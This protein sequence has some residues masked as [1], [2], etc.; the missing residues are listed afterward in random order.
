MSTEPIHFFLPGPAYVLEEVRQ[1]LTRPIVSHRSSSFREV[2]GRIAE[3][4]PEIFR[5][6]GE[7]Y[8]ASGSATLL[9][10]SAILSTVETSVLNLISGAFSERWH[11]VCLSLG[12]A[13]DRVSVPWGE[14]VGPDLLR[15]ALRRR[16]IRGQDRGRRR[17]EAVTVVHNETSTGVVNPVE[18]IAAVVR[19]ESDALLLVDAVS[20]LGGAPFET[21]AWGVDIVLAGVQKAF[22]LPPGLV[23]FTL[24]ERA[25]RRASKLSHRGFYTDLLRYRSKHRA[26][27]TITTP[28][29]PLFW[30]LDLQV[31]RMLAEGIE[32][33]WGR[34]LDLQRR[35]VEWASER[36]LELASAA[37][38]R[39][40]TVSCL[41][42]PAEVAPQQL[43]AGL[44][45]K[46]FTIASGYGKWKP[47]TF[48]I[49]H[50]GEVRRS[51]LERLLEAID[52]VLDGLKHES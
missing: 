19:E 44:Q 43:I 24:S 39:S 21:D 10:E 30:A 18:E 41:R 50:M 2:F 28:V 15:Q 12:K 16:A 4:L 31:R 11:E 49:G 20:S 25:A 48:R 37:G 7:V 26:G 33:R 17:Y 42:S 45:E 34:H 38:A 32:E 14:A 5:T 3:G 40:R 22:A 35:L 6:R 29:I 36:N 51:D 8:V 46:G 13:A 9:M 1:A 52:D 47:S 27:G 23:L